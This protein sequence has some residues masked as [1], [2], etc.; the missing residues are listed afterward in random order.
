MGLPAAARRLQ[1][2]A[3]QAHLDA[4]L[5]DVAGNGNKVTLTFL[6]TTSFADI[7]ALLATYGTG[8][9][10]SRPPRSPSLRA[11]LASAKAANDGGDK[12]AAITGLEAFVNQVRA[13]SPT[14][15]PA[16]C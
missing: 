11:S 7:D 4:G 9:A 16:T 1:A 5:T 2:L 15:T 8:A 12:A 10:R 13:T 6:V 14:P 3:R